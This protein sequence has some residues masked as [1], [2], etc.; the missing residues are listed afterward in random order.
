MNVDKWEMND[1]GIYRRVVPKVILP[2]ELPF[3][4][5]L[6]SEGF[7]LVE[8]TP[9]VGGL[10]LASKSILKKGE[11]RIEWGAL[12]DDTWNKVMARI[13]Q[14][15]QPAGQ[16]QAEALLC[17]PDLIPRMW[18]PINKYEQI[19]FPGTVWV[20]DK[21]VRRIPSILWEDDNP[22]CYAPWDSTAPRWDPKKTHWEFRWH[23]EN[24]RWYSWGQVA[25]LL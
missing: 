13:V 6:R 7:T 18:E 16:R 11:A 14:K 23:E 15:G 8:D 25:Y 10:R 20:D 12:S 4:H 19:D 9:Y 24:I 1:M 3:V 5:D 17:R 22:D 21:G 2:P